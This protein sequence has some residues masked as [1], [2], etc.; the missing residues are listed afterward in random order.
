MSR[1]FLREKED[2][3]CLFEMD[4]TKGTHNSKRQG[5]RQCT[6][7]DNKW[8]FKHFCGNFKPSKSKKKMVISVAEAD[9]QSAPAVLQSESWFLYGLHQTLCVS[10]NSCYFTHVLQLHHLTA[11]APHML[12]K[13]PNISH[14][15]IRVMYLCIHMLNVCSSIAANSNTSTLPH[16]VLI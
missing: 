5:M 12:Y 16:P 8:T 1:G 7:N 10:K 2:L 4:M 15:H 9:R 3:K 11:D 6:S 14:K 13:H